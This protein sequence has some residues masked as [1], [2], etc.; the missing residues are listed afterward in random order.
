MLRAQG[1]GGRPAKW[2]AIHQLSTRAE[3]S[4]R[5]WASIQ[6]S[7]PTLHPLQ[8]TRPSSRLTRWVKLL[9][10]RA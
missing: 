4:V 1:W 10:G 5:V 3:V 2:M 6:S 7:S 8:A 9:G